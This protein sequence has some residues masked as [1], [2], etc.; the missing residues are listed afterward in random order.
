MRSARDSASVFRR[1]QAGSAG[2]PAQISESGQVVDP[3]SRGPEDDPD[4]RAPAV[5]PSSGAGRRG[6]LGRLGAFGGLRADGQLA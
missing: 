6:K 2:G 4:R 1:R 5:G 3:K